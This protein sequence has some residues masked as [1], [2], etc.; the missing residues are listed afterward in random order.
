MCHNKSLFTELDESVDQGWIIVANNQKVQI[1]GEGIVKLT[2][3]DTD[4]KTLN[5]HLQPLLTGN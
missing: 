2:T 5:L 3:T 1:E 4:G